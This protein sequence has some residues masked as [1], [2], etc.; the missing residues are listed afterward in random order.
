M[1]DSFILKVTFVKLQTLIELLNLN[2]HSYAG[3]IHRI[4][5]PIVAIEPC[6]WIIWFLFIPL[7]DFYM[8]SELAYQDNFVNRGTL[9]VRFQLHP[10]SR[11]S[12]PG[13][14]TSTTKRGDLIN[15]LSGRLSALSHE[16]VAS[17]YT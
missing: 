4:T 14:S 15:V 9:L 16:T 12:V 17:G 1:K 13:E 3:K 7:L 5:R 2:L 10:L 6:F 11:T 8:L